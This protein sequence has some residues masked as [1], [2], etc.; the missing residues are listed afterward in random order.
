MHY[1]K[2]AENVTGILRCIEALGLRPAVVL[3]N[4]LQFL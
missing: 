4:F 1:C 2:V 3:K